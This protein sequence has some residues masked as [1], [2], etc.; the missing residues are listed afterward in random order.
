MTLRLAILISG[1]GSNME[2]VA[3]ACREG[4]IDAAVGVVISDRDG[5]RGLDIA[6]E[7]G[8][9]TEVVAWKS[10][11]DR[12]A[13]ERALAKTIEA[14][15]AEVIVLAGFMRVLS[16]E[17]AQAYEGRLINIHPALLP[18][19]R[20]LHTHARVLAAGDKE[21]GAS[22]HFATAELDGGPVVLQS[23]L[24][25]RP[26]E[27]ESELAARVLATEHVILPRVLGWMAA[28]RLT[29]RDGRGWL[30][31]QPLDAPILEDLAD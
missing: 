31:G 14:H 20:G 6:R 17:F 12:A 8:I 30:D 21:H 28:G 22:V 29:W 27:T 7:L 19:H 26:Q 13:F 16:P 3:R 9:A 24:T 4:D 10:F 18:K 2:A 23:R 15:R 1:R 11:A 25:V 5:A